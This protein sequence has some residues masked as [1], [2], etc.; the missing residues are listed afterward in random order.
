MNYIL[1][2]RVSKSCAPVPPAPRPAQFTGGRVGPGYS[3]EG[4]ALP[5]GGLEKDIAS[6]VLSRS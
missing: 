4:L 6:T 3:P 5:L 1:G 2:F